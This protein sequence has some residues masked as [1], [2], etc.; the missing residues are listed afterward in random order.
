MRVRFGAI[1]CL[2][3]GAVLIRSGLAGGDTSTIGTANPC[4]VVVGE[5]NGSCPV[6]TLTLNEVT[7][8]NGNTTA[9]PPDAWTVH[10]TSS[11]CFVAGD[12][13]SRS[14]TNNGTLTYTELYVY[15]F[16]ESEQC[17]YTITEDSVDPYTGVF[18]PPA[19]YT[20][21]DAFPIPN[22]PGG[23]RPKADGAVQTVT[24]TN[25]ARAPV[26]SSTPVAP[27]STASPTKTKTKTRTASA[28]ASVTSEPST[29]APAVASSSA[30]PVLASTGP[31]HQVQ[32]SLIAG[33]A[34]VLLG[35]GLL[36]AGRRPRPAR[37][38]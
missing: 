32:G 4:T 25:T 14:I 13:A 28:S 21:G 11:N 24:L 9:S 10:L 30:A 3:L 12:N 19:P 22:P 5:V 27:P 16:S 31:R 7:D 8:A 17:L 38:T 1:L 23:I 18:N 15:N 29:S 26:A 2:I 6:A 36:V 37:H 33:I 34:L 35:G 20:F